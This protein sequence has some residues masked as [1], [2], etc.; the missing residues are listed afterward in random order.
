MEQPVPRCA[1]HI[2]PVVVLP[3]WNSLYLVVLDTYSQWWFYPYETA[4][5]SLCW[6]HTIPGSS[7]A[8]VSVTAS[9]SIPA[10]AP[11]LTSVSSLSLQLEMGEGKS[12]Q[13]RVLPNS[14]PDVT[15]T[16]LQ[17]HFLKVFFLPTKCGSY[18]LQKPIS[19][20][21][22]SS[23]VV[24]EDVHGPIPLWKEEGFPCVAYKGVLKLPWLVMC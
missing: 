3:L 16:L 2:Q 8:S 23:P 17:I 10:V 13:A 7:A 24:H 1:R 5:T 4:C 6:M 20:W 21:Y 22:N 12:Q 14:W 9:S 18:C 19:M 15:S 11:L